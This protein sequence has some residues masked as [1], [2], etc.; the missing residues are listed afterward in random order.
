MSDSGSPSV[1]LSASANAFL[2]RIGTEKGNEPGLSEWLV[3]ILERFA[4]MAEALAKGLVASDSAKSYRDRVAAADIGDRLRIAEVRE[5][6]SARAAALGKLLAAERDI[7]ASVLA[8][9]GYELLPPEVATPLDGTTPAPRQDKREP[10]AVGAPATAGGSSTPT[11]RLATPTLDRYGTDLTAAAAAGK[12]GTVVGRDEELD[13]MVLTLCRTTKPNP[14]LVGP[15]G[16]GKTA[17]VEALAHRIVSGAVP[18]PLIGVR[19]VS[20]QPSSLLA[21]AGIVGELDKRMEAVVREASQ[22]GVILFIDEVHAIMGAGGREGTG[23]IASMIKPALARGDIS[24]IA[25]T[26]DDEYRKFIETDKALERRF[27][28]IR[29]NELTAVQTLAVLKGIRPEFADRRG[30]TVDDGVLRW[31]IDAAAQRI[32]NRRFPDKAV[33]LLD[34]VVA[35]A[36]SKGLPQV[37]IAQASDA[38]ERLLGIPALSADRFEQLYRAI[39]DAGLL[40]ADDAQALSERLSLTTRGL[41]IRAARP[42]AVVL[43]P[44]ESARNAEALARL[45]AK[46]LF[47]ADERVV[48]IDFARFTDE[49]GLRALLGSPPSYVGYADRHALDP[50]AENAWT[51]LIC[52]RID[53]A[54]AAVRAAFAPAL[55]TGVVTDFRG[56]RLYFSDCVVLLTTAGGNDAVR[57]TLGFGAASVETHAADKERVLNELF[58]DDGSACVDLVATVATQRAGDQEALAHASGYDALLTTVAERFSA[59]GMNC[60]W[61]P[62]VHA[63]IADAYHAKPDMRALERMVERDLIPALVRHAER[64]ESADPSRV[65]VSWRNGRIGLI[66]TAA[67]D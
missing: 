33:D 22:P 30:V 9:A 12:L 52:S 61:D 6:A 65:L 2:D 5:A 14:L 56:R 11:K 19:L 18:Q 40:S 58:G 39:V 67:T 42:N 34:H 51:V 28:P 38:V 26:T 43:L 66:S 55:S 59:Q 25:A 62:S 13:A 16:T 47:G 63:W 44:G 54:H 7:V 27:Q 49:T 24:C 53:L 32:P 15:A 41:D 17:I 45:C 37:T 50:V 57:P 23:D 48:T 4:P 60:V 64:Q 35:H 36:V 20:L 31:L 46:M 29:V 3:S 21:G 1:P 8:R 10:S